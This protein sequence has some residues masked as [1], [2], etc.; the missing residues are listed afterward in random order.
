MV[1]KGRM[2][3]SRR[4]LLRHSQDISAFFVPQRQIPPS[5]YD[6]QYFRLY[7]C[8]SSAGAFDGTLLYVCVPMCLDDPDVLY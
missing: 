5:K 3:F 4:L 1:S 8:G 2:L 6:M 7:D